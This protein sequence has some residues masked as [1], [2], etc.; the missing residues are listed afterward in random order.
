MAAQSTPVKPRFG[1]KTPPAQSLLARHRQL[2]PNANV[3]VSPLCLG[4]MNF[5]EAMTGYL[6]E[7]SKETA[8]ESM[9]ISSQIPSTPLFFLFEAN[10]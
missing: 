7:C 3:R 10:T 4:T 9:Y 6:G 2:A 8:F 1:Y 5:G